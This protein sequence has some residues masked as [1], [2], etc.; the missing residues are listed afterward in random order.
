MLAPTVFPV[1]RQAA[2]RTGNPNPSKNEGSGMAPVN[3][4]S[5]SG[6]PAVSTEKAYKSLLVLM[7]KSSE[8]FMCRRVHDID[9]D[10]DDDDNDNNNDDS[11]IC[12]CGD[13]SLDVIPVPIEPK[14]TTEK[15]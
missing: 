4:M 7:E 1:I 5:S 8:F 14:D 10:D 11:G 6:N 3:I 13:E 2:D 12:S 9:D 15:A